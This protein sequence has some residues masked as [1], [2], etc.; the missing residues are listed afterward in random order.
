MPL[1]PLGRLRLWLSVSDPTNA[2]AHQNLDPRDLCSH[3]G[4]K[5][6]AGS[7]QRPACYRAQFTFRFQRM[8]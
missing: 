6:P 4:V 7:L 8:D 3:R 2:L 1:L 5:P